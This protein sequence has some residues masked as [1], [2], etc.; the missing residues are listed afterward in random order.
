MTH[1]QLVLRA[2]R[3]QRN[4][5]KCGVVLVECASMTRETPDSIGFKG[6]ISH[7]IE[8][9]ISRSDFFADAQKLC[10]KCPERGMGRFR[11]YMTKPGFVSVGVL[12]KNWG[13]LEVYASKVRVVKAAKPQPNYDKDGE[14]RLLLSELRL[15]QILME[16]GELHP[17]KRG[18][19]LMESLTPGRCDAEE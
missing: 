15:V 16:G 4:T 13:L 7:L 19:R 10:R 3:W 2:E 1:A 17:S 5:Q 8:C 12:P 6:M 9:K 14:R 18:R 11:W